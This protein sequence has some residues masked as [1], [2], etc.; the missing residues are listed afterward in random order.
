LQ[1]AELANE[2]TE[3]RI[4]KTL[5]EAEEA[6]ARAATERE[7]TAKQ[8]QK[9]LANAMRLLLEA[10]LALAGGEIAAFRAVLADLG[11]D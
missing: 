11:G 3:A 6:R 5:A 4:L 8:R 2:E 1:R 9:N 7:M 10:E